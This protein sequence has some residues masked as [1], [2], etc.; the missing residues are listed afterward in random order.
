MRFEIQR[1]DH[2]QDPATDPLIAD[3]ET[4]RA[5]VE[6][7]ARTGERLYIRPCPIA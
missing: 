6:A 1:L 5:L 7:A 4:V 3:A 2:H